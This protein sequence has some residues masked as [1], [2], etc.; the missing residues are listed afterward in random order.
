MELAL[1]REAQSKT[2]EMLVRL[3]RGR[4]GEGWGVDGGG[5][6]GEG[7]EGRGGSSLVAL[8]LRSGA[9][10]FEILQGQIL[11]IAKKWFSVG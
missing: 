4:G 11:I 2:R 10:S 6:G 1:F 3:T 7:G 9:V 8:W 5:R